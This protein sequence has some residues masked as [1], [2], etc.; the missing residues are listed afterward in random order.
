M[1]AGLPYY[2]EAR[3]LR[4]QLHASHPEKVE[5][6][7]DLGD[8]LVKLGTLYRHAGDWAAAHATLVEARQV[9]ESLR[10]RRPMIPR[11][12]PGSLSP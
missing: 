10:A 7:K 3:D 1:D 8:A 9:M 2:L 5:Y 6:A 4:R 12:K 11:G